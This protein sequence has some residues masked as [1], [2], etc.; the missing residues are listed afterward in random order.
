[1]RQRTRKKRTTGSATMTAATRGERRAPVRR[2]R[3]GARAP[4][5]LRP[6]RR[7]RAGGGAGLGAHEPKLQDA[8]LERPPHAVRRP[9]P[10]KVSGSQ[11]G[12]FEPLGQVAAAAHTR[13]PS[14]LPCAA[15]AAR[16]SRGRP[17][18]RSRRRRSA[19]LTT[20]CGR[21][22]RRV[23]G[24]GG[25]LRL[26][27]RAPSTA[28]RAR[29]P[30]RRA[31]TARRRARTPP[32]RPPRTAARRAAAS[33]APRPATG[34]VRAHAGADAGPRQLRAERVYQSRR[35]QQGVRPQLGDAH[36]HHH[37]VRRARRHGV[38][39][40]LGLRGLQLG[41]VRAHASADVGALN[42]VGRDE[43]TATRIT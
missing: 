10:S 21:A 27:R 23:A 38:W 37:H 8:E 35:L 33:R 42:C 26:R 12:A 17:A 13:R 40:P 24:C 41:L 9:P 29:V 22:A 19:P 43:P 11:L 7:G 18:S 4:S 32:P 25:H 28:C 39:Q 34:L 30:A 1:M 3:L 16:A 36:A 15:R 6:G 20:R 2:R 14:S 31:A 5:A